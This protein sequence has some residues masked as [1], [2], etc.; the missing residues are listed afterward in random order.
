MRA[1]LSIILIPI[2]GILAYSNTFHCSFHF[3]DISSITD[4]FVIRISNLQGI[5]NILPRR[6]I[7]YLS[8][9][10]NYHV[11]GLDVLGYHL[12]T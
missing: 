12:L 9:A 11:N 2:L 5:W 1:L 10:F 4:N 3:D 6:F 7:L 8:L